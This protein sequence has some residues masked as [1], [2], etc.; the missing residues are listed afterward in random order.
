[1][2]AATQNSAQVKTNGIITVYPY[3]NLGNANHGWL[4]ARHHFSFAHYYNPTRMGFGTL[5]VVNDDIIAAGKGFGTHPHDNME[6][7]TYVRQ[8]AI[9]HKD[10][11][12]NTGRT[13]AGDVQVMSAGTGVAHSEHNLE[14]EN[15]RLY[16][17]WIIPNQQNV[18]PRWEAREF[19]KANVTNALSVLVSG[20][21]KHANSGALQIHADA[22][23][24]GGKLKAGTT[25][26]QAI[27]HGAYVLASIGEMVVNGAVIKQGDGAEITGTDSVTVTANTDAEILVIDVPQETVD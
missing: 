26:T 5:C 8:G 17:I 21:A 7:I 20:E 10:S 22:T 11:M 12:G 13:G 27:T 19:P 2:S 15:T 18:K 4:D 3:A 16:Q 9:T 24:Y 14:N 6:I 1:M 25:V 23:I